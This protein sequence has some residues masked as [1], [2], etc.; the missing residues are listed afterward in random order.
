MKI[1]AFVFNAFAVN[2]YII[3]DDTKEC[4]IVDPGCISQEEQNELTSFIAANQLKPVKLVNTHCHVD[5][6]A[7]NAFVK[8]TYNIPVYSHKGDENNLNDADRAGQLYGMKITTPPAVDFW[9]D[10]ES[11]MNF[12]QSELQLFHL[13][14]HS[15]GSIGLIAKKEKFAVVGDVLF[16]GS[17]GRTDLNGGSVDELMHSIKHVLFKLDDDVMVYSG[18]GPETTIGNELRSNPFLL[19]NVM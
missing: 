9:L 3:Y 15:K 11:T 2:S 10:G 16:N 12:G 18:H 6:V 14:G 5:H 17:V 13:P 1:Q 8:E 4:I 19:D 7:G